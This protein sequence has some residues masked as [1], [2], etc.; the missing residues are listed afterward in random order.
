MKQFSEETTKNIDIRWRPFQLNSNMPADKEYNK[1]QYYNDKFGS[2]RVK[3]MLPMMVITGKKV[4][5]SFSYGGNLGN[6]FNSHRVI[7]KAR[8]EGG[9]VLQDKVV[10]SLFKAYF[11]Q[12]KCLTN[13]DTL[14]E[15]AS[16]AGMKTAE[17]LY[18][19]SEL[20]KKEVVKE[21]NTYR[22]KFRCSGVPMFIFNDGEHVLSGAQPPSRILSILEELE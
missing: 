2:E 19:S 21:M 22:N 17:E 7:W 8:E 12:E 4:G 10:E 14:I 13:K 1:M 11:E 16:N 9:A 20:G 3:Q 18:S 6:T 5:I 15:C